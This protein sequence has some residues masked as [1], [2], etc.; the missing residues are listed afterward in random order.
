M[1]DRALAGRE[2]ALEPDHT[3]TL[4]TVN[5][6]GVLLV[7][8]GNFVEAFSPFEV[9]VMTT[10]RFTDLLT[11]VPSMSRLN[12]IFCLTSQCNKPTNVCGKIA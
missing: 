10:P 7:E 3:S 5:N 12:P 4:M 2:K 8:Q 1:F 11:L 9:A 6:L